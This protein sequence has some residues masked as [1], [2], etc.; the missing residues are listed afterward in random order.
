KSSLTTKLVNSISSTEDTIELENATGFSDGILVLSNNNTIE[1]I[2]VRE[3]LTQ[4][5]NSGSNVITI[6]EPVTVIDQLSVK[7]DGID[8]VPNADFTFD[9]VSNSINIVTPG[10]ETQIRVSYKI[11]NKLYNVV[12]GYGGT[13][14][15]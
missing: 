8:Q 7:I 5:D 9:T 10:N 6:R 4:I 15:K 2:L 12:R 1:K 3:E 14:P 13:L 11:N